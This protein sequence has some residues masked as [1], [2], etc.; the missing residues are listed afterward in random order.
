MTHEGTKQT[1]GLVLVLFSAALLVPAADVNALLEQAS[2]ERLGGVPVPVLVGDVVLHARAR[3]D[4]ELLRVD[5]TTQARVVLAGVFPI[6]V[7]L[8]VVNVLCL[9]SKSGFSMGADGRR[10]V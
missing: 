1:Q 10:R 4:L 5:R 9:N 8:G 7:T 6:A 2:D 3:V